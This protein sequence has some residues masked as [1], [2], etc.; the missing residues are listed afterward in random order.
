MS[1][2]LVSIWFYSSRATA[3]DLELRAILDAGA[4][5]TCAL[6]LAPAGAPPFPA[7]PAAPLAPP[8]PPAPPAVDVSLVSLLRGD[9]SAASRC[10][11]AGACFGFTGAGADLQAQ[12]GALPGC[13]AYDAAEHDT[14]ADYLCTAFPDDAY[15]TDQLFVGLI[16]VAV[17]LPVRHV[18]LRL[19]E[20][21][22]EANDEPE[23]GEWMAYGGAWRL[24]LG[25]HA[26]ADWHFGGAVPPGELV[27]W[28]ATHPEPEELEWAELL[29]R[30]LP[31]HLWGVLCRAARRCV[32][33]SGT[34]DKDAGADVAEEQEDASDKDGSS[35]QGS[36]L[37]D[38]RR[39]ARMK[40]LF[41]ALGFLGVYVT[42]AVFSWF[43]F[44][45][46]M[47]IYQRLGPASQEE[48]ARTWGIGVGL[49]NVQQWRDVAQE[50]VQAAVVAVL[51]DRLRVTRNG[52]WL[53]GYADFVSAQALLFEGAAHNVWQQ[54]YCLVQN[55]RRVA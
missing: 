42:W 27:A 17:A 13:Y 12:F 8:A 45:Y 14:V 55:H 16:S 54:V 44:V 50:A 11:P 15:P 5:L 1:C 24:L 39:S 19:F 10:P 52:P 37:S 36:G 7:A 23:G 21:A 6:A 48:F 4:G 40:R 49:D 28:A 47:L 43:I 38:A 3:C 35:D 51:L 2:L 26:H 29:L 20:V 9:A 46:G 53:E 25:R 34:L 30:V 32:R 18:L 41:A 22:N 31:A 33:R